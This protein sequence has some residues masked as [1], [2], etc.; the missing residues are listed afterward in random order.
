[1]CTLQ[2]TSLGYDNVTSCWEGPLRW[3][4]SSW[5]TEVSFSLA[6]QKWVFP[7]MFPAGRLVAAPK[8]FP[9]CLYSSIV[10]VHQLLI[11]AVGGPA[12]SISSRVNDWLR[13]FDEIKWKSASLCRE[14]VW[15]QGFEEQPV[16]PNWVCGQSSQRAMMTQWDWQQV[17]CWQHYRWQLP[18]L[19]PLI[20]IHLLPPSTS[21]LCC[22]LCGFCAWLWSAEHFTLMPTR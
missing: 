13:C 20:P 9:A 16:K 19:S 11:C 6:W 10:L 14:A 2:C 1:M 22:S 5:D 21:L 3:Y 18:V 4:T 17:T 7:I 12:S 15:L 8:I